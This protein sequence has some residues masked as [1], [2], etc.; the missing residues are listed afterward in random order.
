MGSGAGPAPSGRG[1]SA[2]SLMTAGASIPGNFSAKRSRMCQPLVGDLDVDG[3][4]SRLDVDR[5]V[6]GCDVLVFAGN[7]DRF[8]FHLAAT[9]KGHARRA[10]I[11]GDAN[12]GPCWRSVPSP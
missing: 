8:P 5:E 1:A 12:L 3:V 10:G 6:R 4:G 2:G 9:S 11:F 7:I